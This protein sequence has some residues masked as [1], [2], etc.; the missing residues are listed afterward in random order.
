MPES[1]PSIPQATK[2]AVLLEAGHR[3][4]IPTCRNTANLDI[5][6]I[7]PWE[8][9]REH[10]SENL[11][12]LCPNCH[13]LAHDG[14]IDKIALLKY[15]ETCQKLSSPPLHH[16]S[17]INAYIKFEPHSYLGILDTYN[18]SSFIDKSRLNFSFHFNKPF[19]DES[20]VVNAIGDG[21]VIFKIIEKSIHSVEI[22]F[23]EPCPKI[24][25]LEFRY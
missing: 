9:C 7:V 23:S 10:K 12:V 20:Y 4:A 3:C 6:H 22:K 1:R 5:H 18:I 2:R 14:S 16:T 19:Q 13:R 24:I 21:S 25:R 15:K 8:T 11:I 17:E